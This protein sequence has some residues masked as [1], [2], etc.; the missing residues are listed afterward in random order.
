MNFFQK[1][2]WP[3]FHN[4]LGSVLAAGLLAVLAAVMSL[5]PSFRDAFATIITAPLPLWIAA[6]VIVTGAIGYEAIS[7]HRIAKALESRTPP[8][9][10]ADTYLTHETRS[11]ME[12]KE[13]ELRDQLQEIRQLRGYITLLE[14]RLRE[15]GIGLPNRPPSPPATITP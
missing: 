12:R 7:R 5:A 3:V 13:K 6:T 8:E 14:G 2:L 9:D 1:H 10:S 15:K 4:A 11:E